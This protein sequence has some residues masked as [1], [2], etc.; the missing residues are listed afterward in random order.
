[1]QYMKNRQLALR[2]VLNSVIMILGVYIVMQI[3]TYFRDNMLLG[4]T[5]LSALPSSVAFFI[6]TSVLPPMLVF[7][8]LIYFLA[9]PIQRVA[10]C[11]SKNLIPV[12]P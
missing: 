11:S 5:D 6:G 9:L 10:V 7:A 3:I 2:I 12:G 4:I 1:M 8:V